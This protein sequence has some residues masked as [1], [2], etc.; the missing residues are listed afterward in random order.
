[1]SKN[2]SQF[3]LLDTWSTNFDSLAIPAKDTSVVIGGLLPMTYYKIR[4]IG[5]NSLGYSEP[6]KE[7]VIKT[8]EE[9]KF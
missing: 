6:S 7:L 2:V 9:G 4:V 1:M 5:Q 8:L 3:F